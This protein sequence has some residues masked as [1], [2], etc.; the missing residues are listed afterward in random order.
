MTKRRE[1]FYLEKGFWNRVWLRP[2]ASAAEKVAAAFSFLVQRISDPGCRVFAREADGRL[3][4]C[5]TSHCPIIAITW[6]GLALGP[7]WASLGLRHALKR[8]S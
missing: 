3:L 8:K 6:Y 2:L 1:H 7:W 4:I 5:P